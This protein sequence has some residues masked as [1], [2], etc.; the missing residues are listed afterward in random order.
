MNGISSSTKALRGLPAFADSRS[1]ISSALS[2]IA[3]VSFN[4]ASE[5][6][7]G[8]VVDHESKAPRA[9][10]TARSTSSF[11]ESGASAIASPVAG[12]RTSSVWPSAGSTSSPLMKFLSLVRV[13][14]AISP[15]YSLLVALYS[16]QLVRAGS[17]AARGG[18]GA[19][20]ARRT[21][22]ARGFD[23]QGLLRCHVIH[24]DSL[25]DRGV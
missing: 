10:A 2:A 23:A 4:R 15:P 3:S 12:F 7:P 13:A 8:V 20:R 19:V 9:A 6:S 24:A 11:V 14:V 22:T 17:S 16:Y 5:R 18:A 21:V 25:R 1:A